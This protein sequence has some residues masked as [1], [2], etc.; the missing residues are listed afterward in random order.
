MKRSLFFASLLLS[1]TVLFMS[2]ASSPKEEDVN[3]PNAPVFINWKTALFN[4]GEVPEQVSD[5]WLSEGKWQ[6]TQSATFKFSDSDEDYED[7][8]DYTEEIYITY[9]VK[10]KKCECI[11]RVNMNKFQYS[12]EQMAELKELSKEELI[13]SKE[14]LHAQDIYFK[15]NTLIFYSVADET[16]LRQNRVPNPIIVSGKKVIIKAN[17]ERTKFKAS[18]TSKYDESRKYVVYFKK[19]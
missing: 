4:D 11:E 18:W 6:R 12:D 15:K 1:I 17:P 3:D 13:E 19:K 14:V 5:I 7:Y 16:T 2:C 8:E 9:D 10:G